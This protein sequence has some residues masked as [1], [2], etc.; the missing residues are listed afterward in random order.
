MNQ[1]DFKSSGGGRTQCERILAALRER[2]GEWVAMPLLA[3]IASP[4]G[5]GA[6]LAVHARIGDLRGRGHFIAWRGGSRGQ[7]R[8]N[9][10]YYMLCDSPGHVEQAVNDCVAKIEN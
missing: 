9:S 1:P 4:T 10:S 7:G 5:D 6:G 8:S 3:R 2:A